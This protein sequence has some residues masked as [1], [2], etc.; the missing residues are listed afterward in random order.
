MGMK[1]RCHRRK[2]NWLMSPIEGTFRRG[3]SGACACVLLDGVCRDRR[4]LELGDANS[5]EWP[6]P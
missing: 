3:R 4:D 6:F 1:L 2:E 5:S